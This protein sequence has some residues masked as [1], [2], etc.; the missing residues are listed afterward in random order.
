ML[1]GLCQRISL[2]LSPIAI[3]FVNDRERNE[4]VNIRRAIGVLTKNE[5]K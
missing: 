4:K 1:K 5:K 3:K 2:K